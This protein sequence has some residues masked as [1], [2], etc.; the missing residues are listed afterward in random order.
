MT[1][2]SDPEM[3]RDEFDRDMP[4]L[5]TANTQASA[6]SKVGQDEPEDLPPAN[7]RRWVVRRKA[8][9][10]KAIDTGLIDESEACSRY[11][12]T[13]EELQSWRTLI[14]QHC[15]RGL[16]ATKVQEYRDTKRPPKRRT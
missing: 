15:L 13:I 5:E 2:R 4:S 16:R 8:Q 11:D 6:A 3:E 7:T 12:L 10:V 9:V 14:D 1:D